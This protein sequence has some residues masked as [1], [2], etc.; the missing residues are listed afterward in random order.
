MKYICELAGRREKNNARIL[1]VKL[2]GGEADH[3]PRGCEVSG[4]VGQ[5]ELHRLVGNKRLVKL[6]AVARVCHRLLK[7]GL[8]RT[9]AARGNI[10]PPPVEPVHRN[11]E[12]AAQLPQQVGRLT[13]S[14][15]TRAHT[16][17]QTKGSVAKNRYQE[18]RN[19]KSF[20]HWYAAVFHDDHAGRLR[21]PAELLK[22]MVCLS[23]Q[24][25]PCVA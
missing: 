18:K 4:H 10:Q 8:R 2:L 15:H 3:L 19:N 25:E 24:K 21:T 1:G 9:Q 6:F 5:R 23:Q 11:I 20:P 22:Q 12:A 16:Q 13:N 7:T 14:T 17:K